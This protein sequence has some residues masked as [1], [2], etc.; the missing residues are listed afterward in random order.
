MRQVAIYE[1]KVSN[2][3]TL[4][5]ALCHAACRGALALALARHKRS[6]TLAVHPAV[7]IKPINHTDEMR[8]DLMITQYSSVLLNTLS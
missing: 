8:E 1:S 4:L 6:R 7:L 5:H 2:K 3:T